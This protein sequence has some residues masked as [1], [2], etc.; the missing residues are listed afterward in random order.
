[1]K[2]GSF[3]SSLA[4]QKSTTAPVKCYISTQSFIVE[5]TGKVR[6]RNQALLHKN[7]VVKLS[8]TWGPTKL[9]WCLTEKEFSEVPVPGKFT[10]GKRTLQFN[11]YLLELLCFL[12]S[13]N[14][15][16]F[17]WFLLVEQHETCQ[18]EKQQTFIWA[19]F[20]LYGHANH[21]LMS[22]SSVSHLWCH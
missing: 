2:P 17:C 7:S 9:P 13:L 22:W 11:V 16:S 18:K 4:P 8:R 21:V 20:N 6:F 5:N 14:S 19:H 10:M 12:L 15:C 3:R 1:M